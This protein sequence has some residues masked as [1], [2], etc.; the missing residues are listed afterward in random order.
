LIA[1]DP[2][3][4]GLVASLNR[5]RNV[6]GSAARTPNLSQASRAAA[7]AVAEGANIAVLLNAQI[8]SE[9]DQGDARAGA[10]TLGVQLNVLEAAR[11]EIERPMFAETG[12]PAIVGTDPSF[13][14][15]RAMLVS[16]GARIPF[17]RCMTARAAVAGGLM[18][19]GQNTRAAGSRPASMLAHPQGCQA[20]RLPVMRPTKFEYV[21]NLKNR[22]GARARRAARDAGARR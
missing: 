14:A 12:Q 20:R 7:R 18:G 8:R 15:R 10:A 22:Q 9:A 19:Y 17:P 1:E 5:R 21:I 3:E 13:F 11:Y 2:V 4:L 16:L 6:T